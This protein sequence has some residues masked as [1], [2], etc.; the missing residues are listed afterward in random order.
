MGREAGGWEGSF[1]LSTLNQGDLGHRW[2]PMV[3]PDKLQDADHGQ[4]N[5]LPCLIA[6]NIHCIAILHLIKICPVS[7]ILLSVLTLSFSVKPC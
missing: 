6:Q 2:H 7:S 3:L 1:I 5:Q 4:G